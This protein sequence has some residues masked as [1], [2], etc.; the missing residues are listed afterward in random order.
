MTSHYKI[1]KPEAIDL[2]L[3]YDLNFVEGNVVKYILRSPFKGDSVGDLNKALY[4][5]KLLKP[6][7]YFRRVFEY[8]ELEAYTELSMR[9]LHA[10][11]CTI[12]SNISKK[13]YTLEDKK[14]IFIKNYV[15][16][17]IQNQINSDKPIQQSIECPACGKIMSNYVYVGKNKANYVCDCK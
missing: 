6:T 4:Y 9:L 17:C 2:I 11:K 15:E 1:H 14:E 3:K 12:E 5:A 8:S 7:P 10:V 16:Y 13:E